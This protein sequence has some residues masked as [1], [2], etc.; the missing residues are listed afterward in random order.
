MQIEF[1]RHPVQQAQAGHLAEAAAMLGAGQDADMAGS[2]D[3]VM[4]AG[5]HGAL[6]GAVE[7]CNNQQH[8][9]SACR[10]PP[11]LHGLLLP[12]DLPATH[13]SLS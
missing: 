2:K 7:V 9:H 1:G 4:Y 11:S 8:S 10:S 12:S 3:V 6:L 5:T 13:C